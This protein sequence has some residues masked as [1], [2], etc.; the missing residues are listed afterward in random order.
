MPGEDED[1]FPALSERSNIV[2]IA[3]EAHRTQYGFEAKLKMGRMLRSTLGPAVVS[4]VAENGQ[5]A[6]NDGQALQVA[7]PAAEYITRYQVGYAQHLRDALPNA[8]FVAFTGT[9]VSSEDRDTRAVFGDY[10]HVYDMQQAKEDGATVAIYFES[11][12]AKLSL[13]QDDLPL[14]DDEVDELAEDEEEDQQAKLK[15]KWAALEKVVGAEP[16]I[17]SVA[18]DLVAHFEERNKAQTGK[19]MVVAMSREICVHLYNEI[20]KL[21]PDWHDTDPEQGTIKI[22]MTGSASDK[23]LLQPHIYNGQTKK[24]LEKRFKDP[25]D[26]LRLVIVRDMW[27]TGFDAPCVHTLYVDKP[28]KGHNLMQA[29]ARVNRVFKDK[30]GGLVVDYIGIANELRSALKEYTNSKGRGRPTVDAAEAYA[31]LAEK[32][33]ILRGQLHGYDYSDFLTASHKRLAG[34]ANHVL[35]LKDGKKL[36]IQPVDAT[37]W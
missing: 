1:T 2:V 13:K 5:K 31:V 19:A 17:A 29:I 18:A 4:M 11:R 20:I 3:D 34:A 14:I 26:P 12:L 6:A 9:P 35:G 22:V 25:A 32:L 21:R 37:V 27:L 16:R 7:E 36:R 30:Q 15:S 28:M 10:I 8:T 33:D 24:R 23:A